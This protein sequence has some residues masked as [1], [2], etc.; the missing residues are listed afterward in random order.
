MLE[1][2]FAGSGDAFGSGGR[3]QACIHLQPDGGQPATLLDCGATS[4]V[5]LKRQGLDPN[6]IGTVFVS[7]LHGDHFGGLPFLILDGQFA[8]RTRPLEVV[9][10]P[11]TANRL[12]EALEV[13]FPRSSEVQRRFTVDTIEL[14]PG[15]TVQTGGIRARAWEADHPS[16]APALVSQLDVHGTRIAYTGDTSWTT[17]ILDAAAGS[18]LLIAES[19]S[20]EKP[21]PYH[22]PHDALA[23]H[24]GEL[25][26]A[27]VV[28]THMSFDML[29]NE[30]Q[31][32]FETAHDGLVL[33]L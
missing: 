6:E 20:W 26:C 2:T 21:I 18:D 29:A 7:H 28:L 8:K 12:T 22:L 4:M 15:D 19:Y 16:G 27:R 11:G 23:E 9:G 32:P 17:G 30:D 1:I 13:M 3:L 31:T 5:A 33:N 14:S 10:P 24:R 25:D